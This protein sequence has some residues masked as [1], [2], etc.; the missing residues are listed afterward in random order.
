MN[1]DTDVDIYIIINWYNVTLI[2][3]HFF[4]QKVLYSNHYVLLDIDW[5][6]CYWYH[7]PQLAVHAWLTLCHGARFLKVTVPKVT[8]DMCLFLK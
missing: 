2:I 1:T 4:S 7:Q 8:I 5:F 6:I 3:I